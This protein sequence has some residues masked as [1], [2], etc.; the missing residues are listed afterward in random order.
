MPADAPADRFDSTEPYYAAHRPGYGDRVLDYLASHF[1]LDADTRVLDLGCGAGQLAVPLAARTGEV[2]GV[3]PNAAMLEH[4]R[5]FADSE[6]ATNVEW[7]VGSD[8]DLQGLAADIGTVR[9]ATIGRAFHWMEQGRTLDHLHSLT[10]D[11]GGV[12]IVTDREWLTR[13]TR[14]WQAAIHDTATDYLG[15][16]PERTGPVSYDDD[17]WG[18]LVA[19]HGFADVETRTFDLRREWSVEDALGYVF[20][21]SFCAPASLGTDQSA[22]AADV[23][24]RLAA[25]DDPLVE[26]TAVEVIAGRT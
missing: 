26:E 10:A 2:V 19:E 11:G 6:D 9:L 1:G 25:H 15:D 20:S 7:L 14:D 8:A 24:E 3:D 21:L 17:P 5:E 4:A 22:F 12:A 13:G 18:E 23:R 16:V